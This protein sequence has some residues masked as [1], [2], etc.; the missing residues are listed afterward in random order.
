[1]KL[2]LLI[3]LLCSPALADRHQ[4]YQDPDRLFSLSVSFDP[5]LSQKGPLE[6]PQIQQ[7]EGFLSK[8]VPVRVNSRLWKGDQGG[9]FLDVSF[10]EKLTG[11]TLNKPL[12]MGTGGIE[13]NKSS[14]G[15]RPK[16]TEKLDFVSESTLMKE[17]SGI[18]EEI[19]FVRSFSKGA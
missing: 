1:M 17:L 2:T 4:A 11:K 15:L 14:G 16:I 3:L 10:E 12:N 5:S 6:S 8:A 19:D 9:R 18:V 13:D 7:S